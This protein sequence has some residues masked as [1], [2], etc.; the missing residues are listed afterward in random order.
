MDCDKGDW[1]ETPRAIVLVTQT[2]A[3]DLVEV[4][5]FERHTP[6]IIATQRGC[7]VLSCDHTERHD[8]RGQQAHDTLESQGGYAPLTKQRRRPGVL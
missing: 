5:D 6:Q 7:Q 4:Y 8:L 2:L 1:I 3:R